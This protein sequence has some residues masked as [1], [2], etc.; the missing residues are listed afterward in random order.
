[1]KTIIEGVVLERFDS[2]ISATLTDAGGRPYPAEIDIDRFADVDQPNCQPGA[3]FIISDPG[4]ELRL[5]RRKKMSV[6]TSK[7]VL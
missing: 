3:L 1:M 6:P 2:H 5:L 7:L 4:P